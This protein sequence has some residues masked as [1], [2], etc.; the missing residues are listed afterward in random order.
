VRTSCVPTIYGENVVMRLL[1]AAS[2]LLS[3]KDMGFAEKMLEEYKK[4]SEELLAMPVIYGKK[5]EAEKFKGAKYTTTIEGFMPDGKAIQ[6]G[7]SHNLGQGFMKAFDVKFLGKDE[8]THTPW[9]N[10]WGFSTRLIGA[11]VMVHGDNNGLVLPPKIAPIQVVIVPILFDK[12][13]EEVLKQCKE[14]KNILSLKFDVELDDREEYTPGWKYNE[15]ELKGVPVRLE[16][17]PK[18]LDK[19]QVVL[20]RRDTGEKSFS[21]LSGNVAKDVQKLLEDIEMNL[22][23]KAQKF[24]K[25]STAEASNWK[26]FSDAIKQ[27]KLVKVPFCGEI[28]CEDWIKDKTGGATSRLIPLDSKEPEGNCVQCSKKAKVFAYF[29]K[30]Y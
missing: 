30:S 6:A 4:L 25:E 26:D 2:A 7:T 11:I 24:L 21:K 8:K 27:K 9:Q 18:D 13:K 5:T 12:T 14:L 1:D 19:G 23:S 16:L 3:L 10:S 15:W 29:S 20:V 17:G 22:F 28:E